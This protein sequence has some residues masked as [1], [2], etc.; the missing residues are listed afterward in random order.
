MMELMD[1]ITHMDVGVIK[2][3]NHSTQEVPRTYLP[4]TTF[5]FFFD[6]TSAVFGMTG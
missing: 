3:T 6:K 1:R 2:N 4:Q 5:P